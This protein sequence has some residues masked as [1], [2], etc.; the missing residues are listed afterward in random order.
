MNKNRLY[1][2]VIALLWGGFLLAQQ[3][4]ANN[5]PE[6]AEKM[7]STLNLTPEQ[8][9][10]LKEL[11][12][13]TQEQMQ[14]LR[15]ENGVSKEERQA[16]VKGILDR[17]RSEIQRILTEEQFVQWETLQQ[18]RMEQ[19]RQGQG[20]QG[21]ERHAN[22]DRKA[23]KAYVEKEMLPTLR[24]QRAKLDAKIS[25]EDKATLAALRE[26]GKA[27]KE[28]HQK[29]QGTPPDPAARA[30][31]QETMKALV[32]KYGADIDALLAEIQPQIETWKANLRE[33]SATPPPPPGQPGQEQMRRKP[34]QGAPG[35]QGNNPGRR[36]LSK[37]GFLL[38]S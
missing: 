37:G 14:K 16:T 17:Q 34:Q 2:L 24:Q 4:P 32:A 10:A 22:A 13:A 12:A 35:P 5:R 11:R 9:V 7:R 31:H 26:S 6:Q 15:Q 29:G 38:L 27:A 30:A 36:L 23:M 20:P 8:E 33:M 3:P 21:P 18:N 19:R 1:L 28:A 25:P